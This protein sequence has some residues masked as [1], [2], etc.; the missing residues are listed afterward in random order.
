MSLTDNAI[1]A[2]KP[3]DK[4]YK[5]SDS[6]G[7]YLLINKTG[8]YFRFDYKFGGKRKT[9]A[10][11][12]YPETSLKE[13]RQ[14]IIEAKENLKNGI[15]PSQTKKQSKN[16]IK[17]D[18]GSIAGE[19]LEMQKKVW[20][21]SH[22]E[23]VIQRLTSYVLPTLADKE[24]SEI[25]APEILNLLR[26]I[27]KR[28]IIETAHRTKTIIS[29]VF[30]YAI[31]TNKAE[32]DPTINLKG[33]LQPVNGNHFATIT[34]PLKVGELLRAIDGY[35]GSF[36]VK[37]ALQLAAL[38]F[39]RPGELR[40]AEWI[41]FDIEKALWKIPADKMKMKRIHIVPLSKQAVKILNDIKGL[42]GSGRYVFPSIRTTVRPISENT[43]NASLRR[44]GYEKS[45]MTGHGFRAMASTLLYEN[46]FESHLIEMQLAHAER[47]SVKAS[48][49]HAQYLGQRKAMLDWWGNYLD[50]L[51]AIFS[52]IH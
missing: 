11:G 10:F 48:Y 20:K 38:T 36:V 45:E 13:A 28:G 5:I 27:E 31:A 18:F 15:D 8:K 24:I 47:N 52:V 7:L 19:W 21:Q 6:N 44:F 12:V 33:A 40:H 2:L 25:S 29:Q 32:S 4:P 43:I 41:E 23:T 42:T 22:T 49:N 16:I 46:G 3:Q 9:L 30:R 17:N 14:K 1:K 35:Q 26:Q 34:D 50:S 51:K 39:V 37:C